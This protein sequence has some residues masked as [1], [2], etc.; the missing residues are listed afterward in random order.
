[1]HREGEDLRE[2]I[3]YERRAVAVVDIEVDDGGTLEAARLK[4]PDGDRD[5]VEGAKAL[6]VIRECV[7]EAAADVTYDAET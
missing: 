6:A 3:E 4:I 5:V 1:M 2:R 7:V